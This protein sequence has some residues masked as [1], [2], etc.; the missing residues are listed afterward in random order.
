MKASI[1]T[2]AKFQIA[3]IDDRIYGSFLEHLGRAIYEGIY[4]PG[5]PS[6]NEQGFRTDVLDIIR[7]LQ[8]PVIRY[9]GG[10]YVSAFKW[11]DSV[12]PRELRPKRL[13]LAWRTIETNQFGIA[14]FHDWCQQA[15]TAYMMAINLGSR[16]IED[17]RNLLEYCNDNSG[18][19]W[20]DLR[21][22]HGYP[23][24]F[25]IRMWCLGNEMDGPWQVGHK[26]CLL[27]TSDAADE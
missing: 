21:K 20:G 23:E 19:A 22:Q 14:E 18:A 6:S 2:N 7:D 1:T 4:E 11:E 9:P 16:G 15:N 8:V 24:P 5:H 17:A 26:T 25:N 10:N 13:D 12:G 3:P 27:Y